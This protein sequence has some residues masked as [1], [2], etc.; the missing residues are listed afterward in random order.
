MR[1]QVRE[2]SHDGEEVYA[3]FTQTF[4]LEDGEWVGQEDYDIFTLYILGTK[5]RPM[6]IP[7]HLHQAIIDLAREIE[8]WEYE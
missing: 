4:V 7:D 6:D 3:L 5:V 1:R 8:E 2:A